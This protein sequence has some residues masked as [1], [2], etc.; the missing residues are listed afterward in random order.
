MKTLPSISLLLAS[1]AI[2]TPAAKEPA[3]FTKTTVNDLDG[4]RHE[5]PARGDTKATVLIF[6]THDCPIAN[7]F[8]PEI[9][10]IR[11]DYAEKKVAFLLVHVD[12]QLTPPAARQHAKEFGHDCPVVLDRDHALVKRA[13]AT[14]TPEAVVLRPDGAIAYR[15][16]IDDR[17]V[18]FGKLRPAPTQRDLRAA[19]DAVL[20]GKPVPN[21]TTKAIGCFISDQ[22]PAN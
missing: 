1:L 10:R 12:P 3:K 13:G 8:A 20:A 9:S 2:A 14:V 21:A 4:V 11:A 16:R 18:D 7:G 17:Y 15:G 6:L 19:L 5:L 22:K